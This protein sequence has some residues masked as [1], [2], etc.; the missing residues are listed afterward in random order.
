MPAIRRIIVGLSG[1]SRNLPALRFGA[2]LAYD[3]AATLVP[4]HAWVPAGGEL[5]YR[6][7][8]AVC[9]L[10]VGERA[11]RQ[12]VEDALAAAFGGVRADVDTQPLIAR[13]EVGRA[14]AGVAREAGDLLVIGAGRRGFIGRLSGGKISRYCLAHAVCPV[15]AVPPSPLEIEAGY[16][17]HG[18]AFRHRG[19]SLDE[20]ATGSLVRSIR[21]Q[22]HARHAARSRLWRN[23]SQPSRRPDSPGPCHPGSGS[24]RRVRRGCAP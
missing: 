7:C 18:W 15:L 21:G 14:L 8:P 13:G 16:R 2:A 20:V 22:R 5:A 3:Q 24:A 23:D 6:R 19:R 1:S 12:L 9:L 17:L 10:E 4:V 11:A